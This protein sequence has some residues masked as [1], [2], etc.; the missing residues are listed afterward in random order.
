LLSG[1][2]SSSSSAAATKSSFSATV[3]EGEADYS[4]PLDDELD[5]LVEVELDLPSS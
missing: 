4:V 5:E 1:S 3:A 2:S